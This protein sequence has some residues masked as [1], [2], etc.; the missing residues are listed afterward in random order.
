G[1]ILISE[2]GGLPL[3]AENGAVHVGLAQ[4]HAGV[5]HEVSGWE[6]VSAVNHQIIVRQNAKR[7]L[8]RKAGIEFVDLELR[9]N[10]E[11]A[12]GS[13]VQLLPANVTRAVN[14]LTLE[15]GCIDNVKIHQADPANARRGQ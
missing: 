9:V 5:V 3:K 6:V 12:V 11:H 4:K 14:H 15:I 7:I 8:T 1:A 13:R 2:H 10:V